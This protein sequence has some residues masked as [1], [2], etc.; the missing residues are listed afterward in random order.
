M[1]NPSK[2][3]QSSASVT[4]Q[5]TRVYSDLPEKR[6]ITFLSFVRSFGRFFPRIN[7]PGNRVD[8]PQIPRSDQ[9][10][11]IGRLT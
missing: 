1:P 9:P 6:T 5:K 11:K 8:I 2:I 7:H 3:C 4:L 10:Y